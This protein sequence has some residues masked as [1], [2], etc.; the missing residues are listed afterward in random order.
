MPK[1]KKA[2]PLTDAKLE[3]LLKS[4]RPDGLVILKPED[5][6]AVAETV[7]QLREKKEE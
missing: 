3:E 6:E 4:E 7:R 2:K 1:A 5:A